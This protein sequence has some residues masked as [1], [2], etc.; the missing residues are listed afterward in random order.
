M[1][2]DGLQMSDPW[3]TSS[4]RLQKAVGGTLAAEI[5][6]KGYKRILSNVSPDGSVVFKELDST[7]KVIGVFTP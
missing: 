5:R 3:I 4:E 6:A 7:G 1:T 2:N